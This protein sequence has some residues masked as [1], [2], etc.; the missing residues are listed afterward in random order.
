MNSGFLAGA[1]GRL[2]PMFVPFSFF[3]TATVFHVL[4]WLVAGLNAESIAGFEGGLGGALAAVHILTL[5][6]FVMTVIG[7]SLQLLPVATRRA[8]K[9]VGLVRLVIALIIGGVCVLVWGMWNGLVETALGGG[10]ALSAGLV[11]YAV[12]I[13]NNLFQA[14]GLKVVVA[15]CWSAIVSLVVLVVLGLTLILDFDGG[16]LDD[17]T[18]IAGVHFVVAIFGFMGMLAFGFSF[19]LIPMFALAKSPADRRGYLILGVSLAAIVLACYGIVGSVNWLVYLAFGGGIVASSFY[20]HSMTEMLKTG[21]R[22]RL[23]T[24]FVLVRISWAMLL[25]SLV[26]GL[27][28]W[29]GW[30]P[31]LGWTLFGFALLVGW[32]LTFLLG[33]LLRIAP[34][35]ASM[36]STVGEGRPARLSSLTPEWPQKILLIC[37]PAALVIVGTGIVLG[38]GMVVQV[39]ALSGAVGALSM[40]V[41]V[42]DVIGRLVVHR[43]N[44]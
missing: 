35:L 6:V 21:M 5:G 27:T 4:F 41:F 7:A 44:S 17:H 25:L 18:S 38:E 37:H 2:L 1:Q 8:P 10:G 29:S 39:G 13:G 24:P 36:H 34:F 32:L 40:L 14:K 43:R 31:G 22:K 12:L 3:V 28:V 23:G 30:I 9:A 15:F 26:L 42:V 16:F 33:I 20:I 19:I 11:I